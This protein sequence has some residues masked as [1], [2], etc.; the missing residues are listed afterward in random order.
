MKSV[1]IWRNRYRGQDI[2]VLGAHASVD[3]L[4]QSYLNGKIVIAVNEVGQAWGFRPSFVVLKEHRESV[5]MAASAFPD[6]PLIVSRHPYGDQSR[7]FPPIEDTTLIQLP[8]LYVFDHEA[9]RSLAGDPA[10]PADPDS[11]VVSGS[12]ITRA[13]HFAAY[14]GAGTILVAGHAAG[15]LAGRQYMKG[16]GAAEKA[17][18]YG[19]A[20][21]E[22][23][24]GIMGQ[25]S[26]VKRQ[27]VERYGCRIYGLAPWISPEELTA[28]GYG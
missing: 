24:R 14:L 15:T 23:M 10:L 9:N 18:G 17:Q 26:A 28:M 8:N 7:G 19:V 22:W 1:T 12:T 20:S 21:G 27:L 13:I 25:T 3:L 6:T 16:Y 5:L 4:D 11:L 2:Y